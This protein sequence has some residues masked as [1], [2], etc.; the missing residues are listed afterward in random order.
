MLNLYLC[1]ALAGCA[2]KQPPPTVEQ[3][4]QLETRNLNTDYTTAF[5]AAVNALQDIG[6]T[7][8]MVDA[9][10]GLITADRQSDDELGNLFPEIDEDNLPAWAIFAFIVTGIIVIIGLIAII[11]AL[12]DGDD[13]DDDDDDSSITTVIVTD[14]TDDF[15]DREYYDY[16]IT[17]NLEVVGEAETRVRTSI[18][19]NKMQ[20]SV[21]R[22]GGSVYDARFFQGFY[23]SLEKSVSLQTETPEPAPDVPPET[24]EPD[25]TGQP[26]SV[27]PEPAD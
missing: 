14:L 24:I 25:T 4:R 16:R 7:I 13:D 18:K 26:E 23:E 6:F 17:M 20:G 27:E 3:I 15:D 11:A 2:S 19:R 8:D 12:T 9:D 22:E 5:D 10:V 21:V 1:L